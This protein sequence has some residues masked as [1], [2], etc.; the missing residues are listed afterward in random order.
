MQT[1]APIQAAHP[2]E[3]YIAFRQLTDPK[4]TVIAFCE[5]CDISRA[6]YYRILN[7][8]DDVG[9]DM[10][11]KIETAT[12]GAITAQELFAAWLFAKRNPRPK[13]EAEAT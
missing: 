8:A 11:Q 6:A 5:A 10:F 13:S 4:F 9:T 2:F 3:R 12:R 1:D 7:G